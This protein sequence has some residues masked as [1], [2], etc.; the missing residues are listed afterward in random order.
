MLQKFDAELG[1]V[2]DV[3]DNDKSPSFRIP[4]SFLISKDLL[5]DN[6]IFLDVTCM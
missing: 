1:Y 6:E 5:S 2:E 4:I 3:G